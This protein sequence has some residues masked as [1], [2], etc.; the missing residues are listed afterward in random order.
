MTRWYT[1]IYPCQ[2]PASTRILPSWTPWLYTNTPQP[3]S[4][5]PGDRLD[6]NLA[7][8]AMLLE[9]AEVDSV[10]PAVGAH[11][12]RGCWRFRLAAA[13]DTGVLRWHVYVPITM[14]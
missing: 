9:A 8:G 3:G 11:G 2:T 12:L 10:F 7:L 1:R 5:H 6:S 13:T 14:V 4:R